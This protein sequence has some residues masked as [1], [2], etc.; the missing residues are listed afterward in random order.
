[1]FCT[2]CGA[3]L[4]DGVKFCTVCGA[5]TRFAQAAAQAAPVAPA[6]PAA[7]AEPVS[8]A[9][10]AAPA[11]SANPAPAQP[12][13]GAWTAPA[14]PAAPQANAWPQQPAQPQ[15]PQQWTQPQ[16]APAQPT[17]PQQWNQQP[18]TPQT[19][20]Q[21]WQ[22]NPQ[23]WQ[24]IQQ[25]WQQQQQTRQQPA[26]PQWNQQP[27]QWNQQPPTPPRQQTGAAYAAPKKKG[28]GGLIAGIIALVL[29]LVIGVGGFVWPGF[30]K[31]D[32][33]GG[34]GSG[35]GIADVLGGGS[36]SGSVKVS[37]SVVNGPPEKYYQTVEE[38]SADRLTGHI[39]SVYDNFFLSNATSEDISASGKLSVEPGEKLRE[40][41][42]DAVGEELDQLNP[43]EDLTWL[44]SISAD[45]DVSRKGDMLGLSLGVQLNSKDLIHL[46]GT[47]QEGGDFVISVPELSDKNMTVPMDD[48]DL[49][50]LNLSSL[51]GSAGLSSVLGSIAPE[52]A[53]NLEPISKALPSAKTV[54]KL[55]NKYLK[56]AVGLVEKVEKSEG[57]LTVDSVSA[58][59]T[60]L[61]A[62]IDAD[63]AVKLV[64]KLGPMLKEDGDIKKIIVDVAT[65]AGEDGAAKYQE[66]LGKIDEYVNDPNKIK[67]NMDHDVV[68]T[69]YLDKNSEVHGRILDTGDQKLEMLMPEKDGAFG[70]LL[71]ST[72][73]GTE[74]FQLQGSG[75]RSGDKLTGDL[76]LAV[77]G[78]Y[79]GVVGLDGFDIEKAKDGNFVGGLNLKPSAS[80][81]TKL[82]EKAAESGTEIPE[83]IRSILDTLVFHLDLNTAKDKGDLK[84][85]VSNGSANFITI[86]LS[87][88]KSTAK[89]ITPLTGVE[90]SE[91]L[92]DISLD[93]LEK[94]VESLEKAGVPQV[95]TDLLDQELEDSFG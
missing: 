15:Q 42:L 67:E 24:Q 40:L 65:A 59:Y 83:S 25:Q 35:G 73:N 57:T 10:P 27:Q 39:A 34:S 54:E 23:Q 41:L 81:W 32:K 86:S 94:V 50:S 61:K 48:F 66:F 43:G 3:E 51:A 71:R 20:Q 36:G 52:A 88:S 92:E 37:K 93:K 63:T 76:D 44:K 7:S 6:A 12:Q 78:E 2:K 49:S 70:L 62:T 29:V 89:K 91:W 87:G 17:Q 11:A 75:K 14:A 45:Y 8:P 33:D 69:V 72:E 80:V 85:T 77:E 13:A 26:Q 95:Y 22:Q 46:V 4:E 90:S 84:L 21:Q 5:P 38:N 74:K 56:E 53:E 31:K 82:T 18:P 1:M 68:V 19:V 30:L 28:K 16:Q 58:D 79:Y 55:L 60:V 9:A 47:L 64:E